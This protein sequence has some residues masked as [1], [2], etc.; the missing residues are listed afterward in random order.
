MPCVWVAETY[1]RWQQDAID[2]KFLKIL[3]NHVRLYLLAALR[4]YKREST[5][6]NTE[7]SVGMKAILIEDE[8]ILR[9]SFMRNSKGV[10]NLDIVAQFQNAKDALA[11]TAENTIDLA[12][13]DICL[14]QTSG[15]ELA[16]SLRELY[17]EIL[18]VFLSTCEEYA[19]TYQE[20]GG[21]YCILK[22]VRTD[23][24]EEMVHKML[25]LCQSCSA[26]RSVE[27]I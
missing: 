9:R 18:I 16:V 8:S 12:L 20:I 2:H 5:E 22:P 14:P 3:K 19:R 10:N 4:G 13:V 27:M 1:L 24:I 11:Y 23:M 21:D 17:P 25:T 26:A 7:G 15:I 6:A